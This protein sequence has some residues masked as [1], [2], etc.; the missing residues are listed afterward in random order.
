ME[1]ME[2]TT[3]GFKL[4]EEDLKLR[5]PGDYFGVR[6]SGDPE[7]RA[8]RLGD[9]PLLEQARAEADALLERDPS[10]SAPELAGL[11]MKIAALMVHAAESVH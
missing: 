3:D 5:G 10:L 9:T 2:R 1:L 4:A 6:Q 8:A 11:K 7:L